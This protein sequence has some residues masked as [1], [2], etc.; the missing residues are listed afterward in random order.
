MMLSYTGIVAAL[1]HPI[2][3]GR[4]GSIYTVAAPGKTE[5]EIVFGD[6]HATLLR[7]YL[8]VRPAT[9][10]D[11]LFVHFRQQGDNH[12]LGAK[13][14]GEARRNIC[15]I[16]NVPAITFQEMRK[17]KGT[18]IA[19]E[20]GLELAAEALGHVSGTRVIREYYY[21]PDRHA[22]RVAILATGRNQSTLG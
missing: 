15:K 12:P 20:Y 4:I 10:H 8:E 18:K 19:R 7:R 9:E 5:I 13:G 17:L 11:R 21:D 14:L 6:W 1:D 2:E 22:A 3:D 16:A